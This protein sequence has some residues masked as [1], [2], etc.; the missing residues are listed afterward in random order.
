MIILRT[1]LYRPS[2]PAD[3]IVRP[4]LFDRLNQGLDRPLILVSS[5][6]GYG[7]TTLVR[8]WLD[9][10]PRP[11]AWLSLDENDNDL[12]EFL[13]YFLAAVQTVFP[14][15]L[16]RTQS[17]LSGT[18]LPPSDV[19]AASLNNELDELAGP[20]FLVLDDVQAIREQA[21]YNLLDALLRHPSRNSRLLL[22]SRQDPPLSLG[23]LRAHSR[24]IEI[25]VPELRFS[26]EEIAAFTRQAIG[27]SLHD[28][29]LAVLRERTEG[30]AAGLRLAALTL[31]YSD[32]VNQHVAALHAEN[33]YVMDYLFSEVLSHVPPAMEEFLIKTSILDWLCGPLCDAV[34]GW[35]GMAGRGQTFLEWLESASLFIESLDEPKHW[36]RYH[37]LFRK[38]LGGR[39]IRQLPD[40]EIASLH[41]RGSAWFEGH[42]MPERAIQ[43]ALAGGDT[44]RAVQVVAQHRHRLLDTEQRPL[45]DRW[46][47]LFPTAALVQYPDLLLARAWTAELAR[48]EAQ[49]VLDAV[50]RAQALVDRLLAEPERARQLQGEIDTLRS[51]E[52]FFAADDPYGVI[53]LTTR[54]LAVMPKAW[55]MVRAEAWFYLAGA[56]QLTG[57]LERAY[58]VLAAGQH[59]ET[60]D[61]DAARVRIGGARGF[62][63]WMA[64][65]LAAILELMPHYVTISQTSELRETLGWA[66]YII[67][68]A[69]YQRNDLAAA[70]LH[71]Q[72][73]FDRRYACHRITVV[74]SACI[75]AAICQARGLP[76]AARQ[77][78]DQANAYLIETR[79]EA[80][81]PICQAFATELA[82]L[83]GDLD[84]A[85]RWAATIGPY[86]PLGIMA[87]FYAP[88]LTLPKV[89]LAIDTPASRQQAAQALAKLHAFVTTTHNTRFTID[90]LA[91]QA[92]L[93]AAGGN[94]AAAQRSLVEALILAQPGGFIR[95]FVDLGPA[96]AAL[97]RRLALRGVMPDDCA[98]ILQVF[99][100]SSPAQAPAR[101]AQ[102]IEPLTRR[103]L[104]VLELL[105][106]RYTAKEI[107]R[108]LVISEQTAKRHTANIYQKLGVNSRQQAIAAAA[109]LDH[110]TTAWPKDQVSPS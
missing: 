89:L 49:T 50:D 4:R 12:R 82:V 100:A 46:L 9:T 59:A 87:F 17:L 27:I 110:P 105:V 18:S 83:Q 109:V 7:K 96:M 29:A 37:G 11:G 84:T 58:A 34:M 92:L 103:E 15:L 14:D 24:M 48:A 41:M 75:L 91:L 26:D 90:V 10:I 101:A 33:R 42:G 73:V 1:K 98:R 13:G 76:D 61:V 38:L 68:G 39:L 93:H 56:Y 25:R 28:D 43:H 66:H 40:E 44:P 19:I 72:F 55:Y 20:F 54:A 16:H 60:A 69:C 99:P 94:E 107:A 32:D 78:L 21:I 70:E 85:G 31:R 5:P 23:S 108:H 53:D 64:A 36:Y 52:K 45:L 80:L 51:V 104:E 65:D 62:I 8:S 97:L 3:L 74:Q 95:V 57:Q 30:W 81:L 79:S 6:A 2:M 63:D 35:D 106:K 77:A 67:A 22:I 71:A 102:P 86:V 47:R 88:Q